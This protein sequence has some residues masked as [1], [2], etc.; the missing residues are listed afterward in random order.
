MPVPDRVSP[1]LSSIL[2]LV[3]WI[4]AWLVLAS[5]VRSMLFV[6]WI[7]LP[8]TAHG[9]FTAAF[10]LV[11]A[12]GHQ[13]VMVFFVL[14]GFL[15]GG[16]VLKDLQL[17]RFSL[18]RYAINRCSRLYVV[19]LPALAIGGLLDCAGGRWLDQ[20]GFYSDHMAHHVIPV[21]Y[22]V[23]GRLQA[24]TALA[25][26]VYLQTITTTTFGSNGPLWSLA[27]EF[28]YYAL[29]P[30]VA[31]PFFRRGRWAAISASL[32]GAAAVVWL[33]P[34]PML[35]LGGVWLLGALV[36]TCPWRP[37]VPLWAVAAVAIAAVV[38]SARLVRLDLSLWGG[39]ANDAALGAVCA[40]CL[41]M[42]MRD[43]EAPALPAHRLHAALSDC[44]YSLYLLHFPLLLLLCAALQHA[45]GLGSALRPGLTAYGLFAGLVLL[46]SGYAWGVSLLTERNTPAVR[47]LL[48]RLFMPEPRAAR[49]AATAERT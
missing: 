12:L 6:E 26:A 46:L 34:L 23:N 41:L 4:A 49:A 13:A 16:S 15:V 28:W 5:H 37:R 32:A 20:D 39:I 22:A 19:L 38:V 25:N 24:S 29:F 44:S 30:L 42:G 9:P 14:S 40:A 1:R 27:N 2:D 8:A 31:L 33:I 48:M 21:D 18:P 3:R 10:Y 47:G 17:G 36:R 11:T 45:Y 7:D 35:A 43:P